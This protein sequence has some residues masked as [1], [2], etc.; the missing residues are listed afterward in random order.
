MYATT[1]V[2]LYIDKLKNTVD[3]ISIFTLPE[4]YGI[5]T[6]LKLTIQLFLVYSH[7]C[8]AVS[9]NFR[10]FHRISST[11]HGDYNSFTIPSPNSIDH[12]LLTW[13]FS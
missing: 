9:T 4:K 5:H 7:S 1:Y 6:I 13:H 10:L 8:I 11:C 3:K 12:L 2:Y